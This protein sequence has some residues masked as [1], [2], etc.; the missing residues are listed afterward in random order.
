MSV[1]GPNRHFGLKT[2]EFCPQ[3]DRKLWLKGRSKL[4]NEVRF[5]KGQ[6]LLLMDYSPCVSKNITLNDDK[7][8]KYGLRPF[9]YLLSCGC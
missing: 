1:N 6:R 2:M 3:D 7:R 9:L 5:P 4:Y 8:R